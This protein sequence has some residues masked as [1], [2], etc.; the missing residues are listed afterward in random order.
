MTM[1]AAA[2]MFGAESVVYESA[3]ALGIQPQKR[4]IPQVGG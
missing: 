1:R 3:A 4:H 2:S